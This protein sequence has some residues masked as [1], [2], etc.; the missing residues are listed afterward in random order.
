[1][2]NGKTISIYLDDETLDNITEMQVYWQRLTKMK[3][4]TSQII[5]NAIN[6]QYNNIKEANKT[7]KKGL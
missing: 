3:I 5:K 6:E 2:A 7:K 1:M 4:P